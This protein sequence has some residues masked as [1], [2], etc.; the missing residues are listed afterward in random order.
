M[1]KKTL[2]I[3]LFGF[4]LLFSSA[5]AGDAKNGKKIFKKCAACHNVASGKTQNRSKTMEYCW[6]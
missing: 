1:K 4:T 2:L 3:S 5:F 6:S